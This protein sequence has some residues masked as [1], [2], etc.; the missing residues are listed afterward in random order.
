MANISQL[1]ANKTA[2]HEA[3][4]A[5][6]RADRANLSE[7]RDGALTAITSDPEL[8]QKYLDLQGD[9]LRCS[10]GN[11]ALTLFQLDG[12]TH[13]GTRDYW[14]KLGR[15][16]ADAEMGKGAGVF[17]PPRDPSRR[18][19]FMG[20][21]Y[22]VRQTTGKPLKA[23]LKL[24][25]NSA[26]METALAALL[27]QSPVPLR[28]DGEMEAAAYYDPERMEIAVNPAYS[29]GEVFAALSTEIAYATF[30]GQGRN[31]DFTR[32]E[33]SLDAESVGYL[34]CR[35]FG[36]AC[37]KPDARG[38]NQ[39]FEGYEAAD[40]GEALGGLLKQAQNMSDRVEKAVQPRQQEQSRK[41]YPT[42]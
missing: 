14:H 39:H 32:E 11:V 12:A 15:Y 8:Y 20:E 35:R 18:G 23:P 25:D 33:Y 34:T 24:E 7:M 19:Y 5:E 37:P 41:H 40:R 29:D 36:V 22:D 9:N 4:T 6:R 27:G 16:V 28:E 17:V 3:R 21:Y 38:L 26:R 31:R 1:I 13:I 10:A 42:R 30:H 2:Q